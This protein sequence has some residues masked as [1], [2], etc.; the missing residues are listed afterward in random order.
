MHY[1]S[2]DCHPGC[3]HTHAVNASDPSKARLLLTAL[4]LIG[5]FA[6]AELIVGFTSHSLALVA[7]AGHMVSD[8]LALGLAL[9]ATWLARLPVSDRAPF[10]YR[11]VEILAA[12]ANGIGLVAIA[13]W[14]GW[15]AMTRLQA[16]EVEILGMPMLITAA[17]GLGINSLNAFLLH[18]HSHHDLNLRGAF[19]HM[20]ADAISSVGVLLAA[21]AIWAWQWNWADGAISLLVAVFVVVGAIPLIRQSLDI[22]LEKTP[23]HLDLAQIQTHIEQ[24]EGV[25]EVNTL[26][27]WAIAPGQELL[28]A[29]LTVEST[30]GQERDRLLFHIQETL[31]REFNLS[32]VMLQMANPLRIKPLNLSNPPALPILETVNKTE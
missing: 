8:C 2:A 17:V 25:K 22:L 10:G 32:E 4:L 21:I 26:R 6:I 5:G 24:M 23:S 28:M 31:Q 13:L 7:E 1:H 30:D 20:V 19:L 16:P 15:E 3:N 12:L 18:D 11:R 27:A 9:V 14:I 29:Q